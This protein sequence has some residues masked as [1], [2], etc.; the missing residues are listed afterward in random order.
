MTSK[1]KWIVGGLAFGLVTLAASHSTRADLS[2]YVNQGNGIDFS[3]R[4]IDFSSASIPIS[5]SGM[6]AG[7]KIL[8]VELASNNSQPVCLGL[9]TSGDGT[10]DTMFW[11]E[12]SSDYTRVNDD[13]SPTNYY[14]TTRVWI[15]PPT[16]TPPTSCYTY[17]K[18][19]VTGYTSYYNSMKFSLNI[20]KYGAI[21]TEAACVSGTTVEKLATG[22][23]WVDNPT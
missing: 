7:R 1:S 6:T 11:T 21:T 13:I 16:C 12:G 5:S 19:Y 4:D 15:Q 9:T 14:S 10:G 2:Y 18:L 23:A 8:T 20:W 22:N 17:L 3:A